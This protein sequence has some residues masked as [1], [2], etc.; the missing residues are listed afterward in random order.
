MNKHLAFPLTS[1]INED[2]VRDFINN[3]E[4]VIIYVDKAGL[5]DS[6]MFHEAEFGIVDGYYFNSGLGNTINNVIKNLYDLR[7]KS[8]TEKIQHRLLLSC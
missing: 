6:F 8:K 1:K 5:K 2:G 7:L 4:H 3:M